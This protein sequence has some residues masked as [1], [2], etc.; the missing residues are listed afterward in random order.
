MAESLV[1]RPMSRAEFDTVIDWADAEGWNPGL[2]DAD[3]FYPVDRAGFL[4]G[5]IDN[6]P[7]ASISVP[8]Y[9]ERF[10]F[11]GFYIVKTDFR[12]QGHG[13]RI[14]QEGMSRVGERAVGLDGV[15]DQQENYRKS[16]FELAHRNLRYGGRP[17]VERPDAD[18]G[19]RSLA[20]V[21]TDDV[22]LYDAPLFPAPRGGFLRCWLNLL[23]RRIRVLERDGELAG[24]G[25][26]RKCRHGFK[27]GPLFANSES[28]A[29][30]I[31]RA[32]VAEAG[33]EEVFIDPPEPNKAAIALAE[34][35]GMKPV[36]ETARMYRGKAPELPLERI[37]G[38]TTFEL[39]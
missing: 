27:I 31:F 4:V 34:R 20:G 22:L 6:E 10:A 5:L 3:C 18:S 14:W 30:L 28:G 2:D 39:G 7:V 13:W 26:M 12:G 38:I 24:Y 21:A 1:V 11:L 16:G 32:L 36:F 15:L 29:D 19:V 37:F 9:D 25:V 8:A 33:G 23:R 35:Y 17:E